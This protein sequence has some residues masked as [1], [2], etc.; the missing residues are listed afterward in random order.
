MTFIDEAA[1]LILI[2]GIKLFILDHIR[3]TGIA[4]HHIAL[5]RYLYLA[6]KVEESPFWR[7]TVLS[8]A[9]AALL[10]D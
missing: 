6:D 4:T 3:R 5:A 8:A 1:W 2:F 10:I 7:I 9:L